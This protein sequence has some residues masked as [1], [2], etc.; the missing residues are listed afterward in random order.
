VVTNAWAVTRLSFVSGGSKELPQGSQVELV[1]SVYYGQP[2]L[3]QCNLFSTGYTD[4]CQHMANR[5]R[6]FV[7]HD[8]S[9]IV[10]VSDVDIL[11]QVS[12]GANVSPSV[13]GF[14]YWPNGTKY[15]IDSDIV[16]S[17]TDRNGNVVTTDELHSVLTNSLGRTI[18]IVATDKPDFLHRQIVLNYHGFQGVAR[19][20]LVQTAP[21]SELIVS[22]S[23]LAPRVL[24]GEL[25]GEVTQI[26]GS[27]PI[28]YA[29]ISSITLADG[30]SQYRIR[31]NSYGEIARI[32]LPTG[33]AYEF[34]WGSIEAGDSGDGARPGGLLIIRG[35]LEIRELAD[36]HSVSKRETITYGDPNSSSVPTISTEYD[37]A[38]TPLR[39]TKH[40]FYRFNNA[41]HDP[42]FHNP[43]K[44]GLEYETDICRSDG[45]LLRKTVNTW[46]QKGAL[47]WPDAGSPYLGTADMQEAYDPHI[48]QTDT[49]LD[50]GSVSTQNFIYSQNNNL[51]DK[52]EYDFSGA[53]LRTTHTDYMQ[54]PYTDNHISTLPQMTTT[55]D[56][57][58]T[59]VAETHF[60]YD[61]SAVSDAPGLTVGRDAN[62]G[63][64][65]TVRGNLTN[66]ATC[67]NP[68][69]CTWI[70]H[71]RTFDIA[72]NVVTQADGNGNPSSLAYN[73]DGSNLYAF[74]TTIKNA[75]NQ[76]T[77][78]MYDYD[79]GKATKITDAN[80]V[81]TVFSF[82]DGLDRVTQIRKAATTTIEAQT[83]VTYASPTEVD[84]FND[85]NGTGDKAL[86]TQTFYDG[87]GREAEKRSYG[88]A[89]G[90]ISTTR[91]YDALGR[92]LST[93]NPSRPNDGQNFATSYGYDALGR[94]TSVTTIDGGVVSNSYSGPAT[95][96]TDQDQK[97]RTMVADGLGR[98]A[99]VVEDPGGSAYSTTYHYDALDDLITVNQSGQMRTFVY[100]SLQRLI[101]ATNPET[102]TPNSPPALGCANGVYASC[103][104]Y[105]SNGNLTKKTDNGGVGFAYSYDVLNRVQSKTYFNLATPVP[106]VNYQSAGYTYDDPS[107]PF[108]KGRLTAVFTLP[109][110]YMLPADTST[111]SYQAYD[112]LGRVVASSQ[113]T[114]GNTYTFGNYSYNLAG[115]LTSETYPSGRVVKTC[116]DGLNRV[117]QVGGASCG[118]APGAYA[119]TFQYA[120]H[121]A[122]TQ[123]AMGNGVLHEPSYNNRLQMSGFIDLDSKTGTQLLNAALNWGGSNNNGNLRSAAFVGGG[124]TFN[125]TF[126][127]DGVNRLLTAS[128]SGGWSR[129]FGYDAYGNMTPS[130]NPAPPTVSF[131]GNNQIVGQTYDQKG[132]Q[133]TV[134]GNTL[135]Y[136]YE[137]RI[138]YETDG[139]THGVE[140]YVYDGNGQRV[141]KYGSGGTPRTVFVYDAMGQMAAEYSTMANTSP[142]VT[143][144]LSPD[145]LGT[146]RL[147]TDQSGSVV[148]RHDYLPFGEEVQASQFGRNVHWGAGNDSVNQK[149]TGKQRD[150]ESGLDYFGA[151]YYGSTLGRFT[152]A[153]P[154]TVTPARAA[155]PQQLNLYAYGRNSPLKYVDPTGL[156]IDTDDLSEKDK[157]QWQKVVDLANK[158]DDN[159]NYV[160][161]ALHAAYAALDADSRV[162]KIE[163]NPTLGSGTAGQF[164]ITKFNGANDFSEARVDLNFKVIKGINSATTGDFDPSFQ[165]YS[166]L[167]GS[168][169][170]ISRLAETFGHEANHG[171]FAQQDPA[172][173]TAIQK[174]LN[175][176]DAAL[177]ALPAKGRY[178]LPP[179]VMQKVQDSQRALVPSER[180]AQQAEKII[181]GELKANQV[182]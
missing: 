122:P 71:P 17:M 52:A 87:F 118:N 145:H 151:R 175:G 104:Y 41:T 133:L 2:V 166:G 61:E 92:L 11:D 45:T 96:T 86:R 51:T 180:F 35:V 59:I 1:D 110:T 132:N 85:Q 66:P 12:F 161:P 126:A 121:G 178:P 152:S 72:G 170:F 149:F 148:A 48:V 80:A 18:N 16:T 171:I 131:N 20:I 69:N 68:P 99:S 120:P 108:S 63:T 130:G 119:T 40:Y 15:R 139:V 42:L 127:Y 53:L 24:Y 55:Y 94:T 19:S 56:G 25:Y 140:T 162:F 100:D 62:Y 117:S 98:L 169:G 5:G 124:L 83:N 168:S 143:C 136:D 70:N 106:T 57:S 46:Q 14:L 160:N 115:A 173:G 21:F 58:Q 9:Q 179:D 7:S 84:V 165:K 47:P 44:E 79:I 28:D 77:N 32:E 65:F 174:I 27:Q 81:Q 30:I 146:T 8:G 176:R 182:K 31:Y 23:F 10:F 144:Y 111:T 82:N 74:P 129:S 103:Y 164:T 50:D 125:Q 141:Q 29:A 109:G 114:A 138:L 153:D 13:S 116:Y 49:T 73:D 150:S 78:A 97:Q 67:L 167:L 102:Y 76:A 4:A 3:T 38:N 158:Q 93:T 137:N 88:D 134:N 177:Q 91:S 163:D 75:L 101:A 113:A 107:V 128:D 105:D 37:S 22:G 156:I 34:T 181:N 159:G 95:T 43:W 36:G 112:P 155:D 172:Q 142:C 154:I 147:L 157:K 135:F 26:V 60:G 90:Y 39:I 54:S 64:G 6:T 123:Y 33:G 89:A